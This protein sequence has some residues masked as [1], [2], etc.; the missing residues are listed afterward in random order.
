MRLRERDVA[1]IKAS[2]SDIFGADAIVRLFGSR[3]DDAARG[4][5]IDLHVESTDGHGFEQERD[6]RRRLRAR[7]S[8]RSVDIVLYRAGSARR[9]I[10][11]VAFGEGVVL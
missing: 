9:P 10:D 1:A 6:L 2:V 4:G 7:M 5:D 3:V 8:D 11:E